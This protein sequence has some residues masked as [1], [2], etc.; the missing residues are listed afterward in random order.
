M[1]V[2][3]AKARCRQQLCPLLGTF[4]TAA[5]CSAGFVAAS[6]S[7]LC[8]GYGHAADSSCVI[9]T[10]RGW[11]GW[12]WLPIVAEVIGAAWGGNWEFEC[13]PPNGLQVAVRCVPCVWARAYPG[14][15]ACTRASCILCWSTLT[16]HTPEHTD[17]AVPVGF[18]IGRLVSMAAVAV[19]YDAQ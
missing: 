1:C 14:G 10:G 2:D 8:W 13:H 4:L 16:L 3:T 9:L 6:N 7:V 12:V 15:G 11:F 18:T 19:R 17:I 5:V